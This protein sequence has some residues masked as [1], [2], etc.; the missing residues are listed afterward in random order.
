MTTPNTIDELR[1]LI[2]ANLKDDAKQRGESLVQAISARIAES[3]K[4]TSDLTAAQQRAAIERAFLARA[5]RE[6][7]I[8]P[9]D[10]LKLTDLAKL[11]LND[12][13]EIGGLDELFAELRRTRPWL[14]AQSVTPGLNQQERTT[15]P[16]QALLERARQSGLTRDIQLWRE[17]R[18]RS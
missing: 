17:Q 18:K 1:A 13:G 9:D 16:A 7:L 5:A 11:Q 3:D 10:A 2:A 14:F 4:R 12:R 8:A 15:D 6:Q